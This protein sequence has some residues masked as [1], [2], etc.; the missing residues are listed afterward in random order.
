[1]SIWSAYCVALQA[2]GATVG[3]LCSCSLM[4]LISIAAAFCTPLSTATN[5]MACGTVLTW[6]GQISFFW[7]PTIG[8]ATTALVGRLASMP[9][10]DHEDRVSHMVV[11]WCGGSVDV[12]HSIPSDDTPNGKVD[13]QSGKFGKAKKKIEVE[14][15]E[16]QL[17][18]DSDL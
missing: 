18:L 16:R 5:D 6:L 15:G 3:T 10:A 7:Y 11:G 4:A 8:V 17:M 9:T 12:T 14:A 13:G 1:M 2:C